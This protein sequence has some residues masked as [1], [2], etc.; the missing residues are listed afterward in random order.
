VKGKSP[1]HS[2]L[3]LSSTNAA[4]FKDSAA[5]E[6]AVVKCLPLKDKPFPSQLVTAIKEYSLF[7]IAAILGAGPRLCNIFGFDMI[8]H[9]DCI[10]FCMEECVSLIPENASLG[11]QLKT[12]LQRL[13]LLQI[14]HLD[15]K[16]ANVAFSTGLGEAVL[17][18]F[19]FSEVLLESKGFSTLTS[20]VGSLS[21]CSPE[22]FHCYNS[23]QSQLVDLYYNDVYA[24]KKTLS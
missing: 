19:G 5:L 10:E 18:D 1:A 3:N 15:I 20:F 16:P 11:L 21:H 8:V 6:G 12:K 22:M 7:K 2:L 24:L 23:S 14:V 17:I 13:H 4:V 9:E